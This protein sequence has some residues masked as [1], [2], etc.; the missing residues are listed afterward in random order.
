MTIEQERVKNLL[1]NLPAKYIADELGISQAAV[2][3]KRHKRYAWRRSEMKALAA[4]L[5]TTE[6]VVHAIV[7][8]E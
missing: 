1:A 4:L 3:D 2:Y 6:Q 7:E 8:E 5:N